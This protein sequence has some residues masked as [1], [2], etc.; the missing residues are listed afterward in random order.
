MS[1][2]NTQR[3]A[4]QAASSRT[5]RHPSADADCSTSLAESIETL[6]FWLDVWASE[7]TEDDEEDRGPCDDEEK[8][9]IIAGYHVLRAMPT[10]DEYVA[11]LRWNGTTYVTCDSDSEGAFKV[12]R[13]P[14]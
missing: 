11:W 8:K 2:I 12:C 7:S 13:H 5:Q 1:N 9:T 3:A 6:R 10:P 4:H 14:F